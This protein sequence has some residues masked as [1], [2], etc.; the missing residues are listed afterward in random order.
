MECGRPSCEKLKSKGCSGCLKEGYCSPECQKKDWKVHKLMCSYMKNDNKLLPFKEVDTTLQKFRESAEL[1]EGNVN[2]LRISEFCIKYAENQFGDRVP[3]QWYR[4]REDGNKIDNW[5]ADILNLQFFTYS[6][7]NYW[8]LST[9]S[10]DNV[11]LRKESFKKAIHHYKKG[12]SILEPWRI[13]HTVEKNENVQI[14]KL[15]EG[16]ID[17]IYHRISLTETFLN[18][19]YSRLGNFDKSND[20]LDKAIEH[21]NVVKCEEK[22]INLVFSAL[23]IKGANFNRQKNYNEAKIVY[24]EL[25]NLVAEAYYVDH[26][27]VLTAAN[28]LIGVLILIK[29]YE[30]AERYARI[31]YECL[32]RPVDTESIKVA[33]AAESLA[34]LTFE[35]VCKKGVEG[36]NIMEAEML[37]RKSL[38]I[39]EKICGTND[40]ATINSRITLSNILQ[41]NGTHDDERKD[42]LEQCLAINIRR[43]GSN[44]RTTG[45]VNAGLANLH[46]EFASKL[47][48]GNA[49]TEQLRISDLYRKEELRINMLSSDSSKDYI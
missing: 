11:D 27:L 33:I 36:G 48:A 6:V 2:A 39:K 42:L 13:L 49:K 26:P 18:E 23:V 16:M 43:N 14:Y 29:E 45:I 40:T 41:V 30:D 5:T 3:G 37:C 19:C 12:L 10:I 32:T 4:E 47:P 22:R 17:Y 1:V 24:E 25:Y 38:R 31:T 9:N 34:R 15:D 35:L 28:C 20:Y 8:R 21:A 44:D 7:A 46:K